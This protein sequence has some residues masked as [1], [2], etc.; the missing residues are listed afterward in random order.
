MAKG[1]ESALC[2]A[3]GGKYQK[4]CFNKH[5]Q[6]YCTRNRC[7]MKRRQERQRQRYRSKYR[8]D[9]KFADAE[10]ERCRSGLQRRRENARKTSCEASV[11]TPSVNIYLLTTGLLS[12]WMDSQDPLEIERETRRLEKRGQQLATQ[13]G[14]PRGSP[15]FTNF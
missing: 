2:E 5:H 11:E 13:T 6:K 14:S 1:R 4:C 7:V 15:N 8:N 3:C 12:Q 9:K 10:R